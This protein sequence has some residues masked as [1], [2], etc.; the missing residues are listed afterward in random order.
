VVRSSPAPDR[1]MMARALDP[2]MSSSSQPTSNASPAAAAA[3]P[4]IRRLSSVRFE[5]GGQR[6]QKR[7]RRVKEAVDQWARESEQWASLEPVARE[8]MQHVVSQMFAHEDGD[9]IGSDEELVGTRVQKKRR[10]EQETSAIE[11][12]VAAAAAVTG[13]GSDP[14]AVFRAHEPGVGERLR[15]A[16][17]SGVLREHHGGLCFHVKTSIENPETMPVRDIVRGVPLT[18]VDEENN[19]I[20]DRQIKTSN[21]Q[22]VWMKT[23]RDEQEFQENREKRRQ[24]SGQLVSEMDFATRPEARLVQSNGDD[25]ID[26]LNK[27]L[28]PRGI[29]RS[30]DQK[31]FHASMVAATLPLIYGVEWE[32]RNAEVLK[33]HGLTS[34][35]TEVLILAARRWGKTWAVAMY[36]VALILSVPGVE[37]CVFSPTGRQSGML[38][39]HVR[40]FLSRVEGSERRIVRNTK[41]DLFVCEYPLPVGKGTHSAEAQRRCT[42]E[43]TSKVH[44]LPGTVIGKSDQ[45]LF[46][47]FSL[48]FLFL[49]SRAALC[50]SLL[51]V[52]V[53]YLCLFCTLF[54]FSLPQ[55]P[56]HVPPVKAPRWKADASATG[57]TPATTLCARM[58]LGSAARC[59]TQRTAR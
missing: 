20:E 46:A 10:V 21:A 14:F 36:I 27:L 40:Q 15:A 28:D 57:P 48:L 8:R 23:F 50:V 26:L 18:C 13:N 3:P 35:E 49:Q 11:S 12:A 4:T 30:N 17:E 56:S 5:G 2:G 32:A 1:A 39:D 52:R 25:R 55:T 59:S 29:L 43:S 34:V 19:L 45:S 33:S 58:A 7:K 6:V 24:R 42:L 9:A 54:F 47:L 41:E 22:S 37:V 53:L 31:R 38:A 44:F 16:C 51:C